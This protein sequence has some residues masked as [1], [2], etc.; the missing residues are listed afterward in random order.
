MLACRIPVVAADVGELGRMLRH[1][2]HLLY[3]DGDINSFV[4]V[5]QRQL[6][7][8]ELLDLEV[9]SWADQ[10]ESLQQLMHSVMSVDQH[11]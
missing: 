2:P 7:K 10:A 4:S 6:T 1:K 9:P 5:I 8:R 3:K 11:E